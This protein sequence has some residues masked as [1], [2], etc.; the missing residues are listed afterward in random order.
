MTGTFLAGVSRYR[1]QR[2][3]VRRVKVDAVSVRFSLGFFRAFEYCRSEISLVSI[4]RYYVVN[5]RLVFVGRDGMPG[6]YYLEP[7]RLRSAVACLVQSGWAV[8]E[9]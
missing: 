6:R 5:R 1:L 4:E 8:A 9:Q 2:P 7:M 3:L